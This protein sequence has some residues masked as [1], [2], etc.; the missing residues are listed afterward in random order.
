MDTRRF[1]G[2]FSWESLLCRFAAHDIDPLAESPAPDLSRARSIA[3]VA[4]IAADE[5]ADIDV[6]D[7]LP[8]LNEQ[9]VR[10]TLFHEQVHFWQLISS[11]LLQSIFLTGLQKIY[12]VTE[13]NGGRSEGV[14]ADPSGVDQTYVTAAL[15]CA[16]S[17]LS[18]AGEMTKLRWQQELRTNP[19][20]STAA[21]WRKSAWD[22]ETYPGYCAALSTGQE[23]RRLVDVNP[24]S[25]SESAAFVA[26]M[27]YGA[28][29]IPRLTDGD[30]ETQTL[31]KGLWELWVRWNPTRS[32]DEEA[33]SA[34][35]LAVVDLALL[36]G[37]A[38]AL[39][40][41]EQIQDFPAERFGRLF[42]ASGKLPSMASTADGNVQRYQDELAA[43]TKLMPV[44][45]VLEQAQRRLLRVLV[46]SLR[47]YL[48][49]SKSVFDKWQG[50]LSNADTDSISSDEMIH[51]LVEVFS[52]PQSLP[53]GAHV[54]GTMFNALQHR[55]C[56]RDAF[57]VPH[58]H[59]Q[60]LEEAFFMPLILFRGTYYGARA[61]LKSGTPL[62]IW[63]GMLRHDIIALTTVLPMV[64][65]ENRCGFLKSMTD[66]LYTTNGIGCPLAPDARPPDA[67]LGI[68]KET[69]LGNWCHKT[70]CDMVLGLASEPSRSYW[71]KRAEAHRASQ[72]DE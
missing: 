69:G 6:Q 25:L 58:L 39:L 54:L 65:A 10:S 59:A 30:D 14:C 43:H 19:P 31:Y 4:S 13:A 18:S 45:V 71:L 7:V 53:F 72:N 27:R 61:G 52:Q 40:G 1:G 56:N 22:G 67:W 49:I 17:I 9:A 38:H 41:F 24:T 21:Y 51:A 23:E 57:A 37:S 20:A 34:S 50:E 5:W 68:R 3:A 47:R 2:S 60:E 35:F 16:R 15:K 48:S 33:L 62:P 64:E 46:F 42:A 12:L 8:D 36:G 11:P 32:Q 44:D 55:R 28:R 66:C 29:T 26:E 70:C 63:N